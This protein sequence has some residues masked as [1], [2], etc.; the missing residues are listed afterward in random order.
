M[1]LGVWI[2]ALRD[3]SVTGLARATATTEQRNV[4]DLKRIHGDTLLI[5][6]SVASLKPKPHELRLKLLLSEKFPNVHMD[7]DFL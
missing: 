4:H 3:L 6:G 2:T 7:R 1:P 5:V